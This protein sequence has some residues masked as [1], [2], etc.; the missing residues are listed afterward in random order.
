MAKDLDAKKDI[1]NRLKRIEGQVKGIEKMVDN[2]STCKEILIQ[3]A[4]IRAAINKVGTLVLENYAKGCFR[5][6]QNSVGEEKIDD[7]V[8]TLTMFIK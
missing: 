6:G 5:E 8:S 4:A 1:L 2:E 3:V 7:L